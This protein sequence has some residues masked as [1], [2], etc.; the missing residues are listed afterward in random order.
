M[1]WSV[2]LTVTLSVPDPAT[3]SLPPSVPTLCTSLPERD[4]VTPGDPA[5]SRTPMSAMR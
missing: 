1:N 2:Q 4:T 5:V 3:P